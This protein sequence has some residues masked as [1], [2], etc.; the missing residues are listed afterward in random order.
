MSLFSRKNKKKNKSNLSRVNILNKDADFATQ[1]AFKMIRTNLMFSTTEGGC[2]KILITGSIPDEGKS[3]VC[4]NLAI[5]LSQTGQRVLLI[6]ADLRAP[7]Q[8]R[9]F[10]AKP[11]PGLSELLASIKPLNEVV[12]PIGQTTL[13]LIPAGTIPPNPA[14]LLGS[15]N[16][17]KLLDSL[18]SQYDYILLDSPPLNVVS[19]ALNLTSKVH[20]T[21]VVVRENVTE[22]KQLR[23][24]LD[25]LEFASAKVLG[26]IM[27]GSTKSKDRAYHYNYGAY[28][29]SQG[30]NHKEK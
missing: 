24:S 4:A 13:H 29:Q 17:D 18:S 7:I 21:V 6:D 16:M 1:E 3:T 19:D 9:F 30:T 10:R 23:Q 15:Q 2:K 27:N 14:E 8:H 28:G 26:L 22:H 20:G 12:V 25:S 5:A 11:L